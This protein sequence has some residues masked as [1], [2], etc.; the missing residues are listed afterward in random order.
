MINIGDYNLLEVKREKDFGYYLGDEGKVEVLLPKSMTEK[1]EIN[2]GDK[3]EVFVYRD[4]KDRPIATFKKPLVTVGEVGYLKVVFQTDFGAFV[5]FGLD[6][7]IFVPI[8]EQ[9]FKLHTGSKYLFYV[10]LDKTGRLAATT[11]VENYILN[12]VEEGKEFK[13]GD[14][15]V[16]QVY[17]KTEAGTVHVAID[18]KYKGL[19]L[20]NEYYIEI[21]PGT[22][23][24]L[25]VKRIYEDGIIGL[26][27]RKTR[28][29]EREKIQE[30]ILKYLKKN[31][32]FMHFN[33]KSNPEDIKATFNTSKNYFKMALGGLMKEGKI[34]QEKEGTR[35]K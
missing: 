27:P 12:A 8:K 1:K 28:L 13:V 33:D 4:S 15:V 34:V 35:L 29:N 26:T 6:R 23:M 16:A 14:E 21:Y 19:I 31:G 7:D 10:Y 9:R 30:D 3:L 11:E 5:D 18:G 24:K 32:G 2:I 22:E 25:R 17:G 20:P